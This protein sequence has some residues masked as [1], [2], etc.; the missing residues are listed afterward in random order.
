MNS[1]NSRNSVNSVNSV[2][3]VDTAGLLP[4]LMVFSS[5]AYLITRKDKTYKV[6]LVSRF[7]KKN[8]EPQIMSGVAIS[9][10]EFQ[11]AA[12]TDTAPIEKSAMCTKSVCQRRENMR[13][14]SSA[15][16]SMINRKRKKKSGSGK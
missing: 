12:L 5:I 14:F 9:V 7:L 1:I 10:M 11:A 16:N 6:C 15:K 3:T 4:F 8:F 13:I 2:Q